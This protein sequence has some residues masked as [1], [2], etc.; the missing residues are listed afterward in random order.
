MNNTVYRLTLLVSQVQVRTTNDLA[1]LRH[2]AGLS[3]IHRMFP[4]TVR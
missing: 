4:I 3:T 1:R 2:E